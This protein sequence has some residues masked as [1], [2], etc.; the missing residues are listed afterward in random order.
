MLGAYRWVLGAARWNS[1]G[2]IPQVKCR[3]LADRSCTSGAI[4]R[5]D[6]ALVAPPGGQITTKTTQIRASYYLKWRLLADRLCISS[7][8]DTI[9]IRVSFFFK[10]RQNGVRV[11]VASPRG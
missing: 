5:I 6:H 9:H 3:Q 11:Y 10:L 4:R 8:T 7:Q 2:G 1:T